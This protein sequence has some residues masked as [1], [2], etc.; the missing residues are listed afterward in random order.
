MSLVHRGKGN[1][2]TTATVEGD[3]RRTASVWLGTTA[4]AVARCPERLLGIVGVVGFV[5]PTRPTLPGLG[6]MM[7]LEFRS[8]TGLQ[9]HR[10]GTDT[11]ADQGGLQFELLDLAQLVNVVFNLVPLLEIE[12]A[13]FFNLGKMKKDIFV[14]VFRANESD[15][16][17][18]NYF[19]YHTDTH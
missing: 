16:L 13:D 3:R 4:L 14:K 7:R 18:R 12:R 19:D 5:A 17:F 8:I 2:G 1:N 15:L 9:P 10:Q 6:V 11:A